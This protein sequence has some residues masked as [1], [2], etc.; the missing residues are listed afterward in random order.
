MGRTFIDRSKEECD[1]LCFIFNAVPD[2]G[3]H[4]VDMVEVIHIS[5]DIVDMSMRDG[6][7]SVDNDG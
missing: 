4:G 2:E 1:N 3:N 7:T 6:A 5:S